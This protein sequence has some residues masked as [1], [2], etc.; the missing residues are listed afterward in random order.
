ML[1]VNNV[2]FYTCVYHSWCICVSFT[3]LQVELF[4]ILVYCINRKKKCESTDRRGRTA[5]N[6]LSIQA[7]NDSRE[8]LPSAQSN[9]YT[10]INAIHTEGNYQDLI[11]AQLST[12]FPPHQGMETTTE[13]GSLELTV[14]PILFS[15]ENFGQSSILEHGGF[16]NNRYQ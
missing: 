2:T 10:D 15:Q 14:S 3:P 12:V 9:I 13:Y 16:S 7:I 11:R 6:A 1:N 4:P 8:R 5:N